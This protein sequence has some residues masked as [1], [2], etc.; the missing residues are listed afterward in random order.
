MMLSEQEKREMLED[1]RSQARRDQLRAVAPQGF[2]SFETY[3]A[4]LD[5]LL[6]LRPPLTR[7][8]TPFTDIRL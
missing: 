8:P 5:D 4:A 7:P 1:G 6:S 3:L 2:P